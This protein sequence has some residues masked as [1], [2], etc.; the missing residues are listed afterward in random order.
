MK[1]K[2]FAVFN[3]VHL[4]VSCSGSVKL[5][6]EVLAD[7]S[8]D[9]IYILGDLL[10]FY[11]INFFGPRHPDIKFNVED[12]IHSGIKF[13]EKLK[14]ACP[15]SDIMLCGGNHEIRLERF[16]IDK[17]PGFFNI[18]RVETMLQLERL[19]IEYRKYQE[20]VQVGSANL[21]MMHSPPSYGVNG[22][23]S[24]LLAKPGSSWIFACSHRQQHASISDSHGDVHH[25]WF[26]GWL[27][28]TTET[29]QHKIVY[30]FVK[31]HE[32]WQR[33]FGLGVHDGEFFNY[34]QSSVIQKDNKFSTMAFGNYYEVEV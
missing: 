6:F 18:F 7:T 3:D 4:A 16:A 19:G 1:L 21:R 24:S 33:C 11:S 34:Q 25:C 29:D 20:I 13:L 14:E 30:S 31:G 2:T 17:C 27:G 5:L 28:S 10:D 22:A 32:N 9:E 23:R 26:N 12:E 8:P 15:D